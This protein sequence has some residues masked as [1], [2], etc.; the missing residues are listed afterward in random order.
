MTYV[1]IDYQG[2]LLFWCT[3]GFTK[4][5]WN[6]PLLWSLTIKTYLFISPWRPLWRYDEVIFWF[7]II[8]LTL[9]VSFEASFIFKVD[10]LWKHLV[11]DLSII[12]S[13][14]SSNTQF[15]ESRIF[16]LFTFWVF[17][18]DKSFKLIS[19]YTQKCQHNLLY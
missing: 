2:A 9:S 13:F 3:C 10:F 12:I 14:R 17:F 19:K 15:Y 5:A 4:F 6:I 11:S 18:P 8:K 1:E 16:C 7:R